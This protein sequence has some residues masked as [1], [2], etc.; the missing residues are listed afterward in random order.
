MVCPYCKS[1]ELKVV[2]KRNCAEASIRR[3][4]ECEKCAKRFTTYERIERVT[5]NVL[6]R[7]GRVQEFDR[8]KLKRGILKAVSKRGVPENMID[9]MIFDIE[10]NL[11]GRDAQTIDVKEIGQMVLIRLTQIDKLAALLFAAVYKYF[12]KLEDVHNELQRLE[13]LQN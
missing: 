10:S 7:D 12:Q 5:L 6:K 3:R 8:E 13:K 9:E 2:D 11:M 1:E 4:R